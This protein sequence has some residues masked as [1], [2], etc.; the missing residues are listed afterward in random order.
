MSLFKQFVKNIDEERRNKNIVRPDTAILCEAVENLINER[1]FNTR[2][3]FINLLQNTHKL[4]DKP[5][6]IKYYNADGSYRTYHEQKPEHPPKT[7]DRDKPTPKHPPKKPEFTSHMLNSIDAYL[8]SLLKNK[9]SKMNLE[10]H[11]PSE[12]DCEN[13]RKAI[14]K[15]RIKSVDK[16][17][18]IGGNIIDM[19]KRLTIL[20]KKHNLKPDC[21]G[22]FRDNTGCLIC[23][24]TSKCGSPK[25]GKPACFGINYDP[26]IDKCHLCSDLRKEC[27]A[28][29]S[30]K[31]KDWH[32]YFGQDESKQKPP[33]FGKDCGEILCP[34]SLADTCNDLYKSNKD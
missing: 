6:N 22:Y 26:Y 4:P 13:Y 11:L 23:S 34:Y 14:E 5:E 33:C 15:D 2:E 9:K 3:D 12:E 10:K 28:I 30:E 25:T 8:G 20:E 7:N 21:F 1:D 18:K 24:H 27:R 17:Q 29:Y 31:N 19:E 32:E 16:L